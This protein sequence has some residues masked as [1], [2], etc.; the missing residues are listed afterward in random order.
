MTL[1]FWTGNGLSSRELN[2]PR[3]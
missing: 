3:H 1:V 2:R